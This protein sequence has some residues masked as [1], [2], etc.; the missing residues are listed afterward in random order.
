MVAA[1]VITIV[2]IILVWL[3][4][5]KFKVAKFNFLW[6][7]ATFWLGVHL[8]L[9]FLIGMRF[10]QPYAKDARIIHHTIQMCRACPN[11]RC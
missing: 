1:L 7:I 9:V 4:F 11:R 6:G 5:F 3:R 2:Y 8:L 10:S